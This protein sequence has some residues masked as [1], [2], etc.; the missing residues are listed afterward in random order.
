M[1]RASNRRI[2]RPSPYRSCEGR[3]GGEQHL[4]DA[5][6]LLFAH[7]DRDPRPVDED[8]D[9]DRDRDGEPGEAHAEVG[10]RRAQTADRQAAAPARSPAGG[11]GPRSAHQ[12]S[13]ERE[14]AAHAGPA[15]RRPG[16]VAGD[17]DLATGD[18]HGREAAVAQLCFSGG[19]T[20]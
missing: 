8:D 20:V 1:A 10:Q 14:G 4:D 17:V 6:R 3:H 15:G 11:R 13:G 12:S 9:V 16:G 7:A 19:E 2:S 5:A 18:E